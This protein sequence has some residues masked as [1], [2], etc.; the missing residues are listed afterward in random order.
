[1]ATARRAHLRY[2]GSDVALVV[3]YGSQSELVS[4]FEETHRQ[5]Y[6]FHAPNKLLIVESVTV[7]ATGAA[8]ASKQKPPSKTRS[9]PPAE[10][11]FPD[12]V[13]AGTAHKTPVYRR[14]DLQ[15]EDEIHGP[16]LIVEE[17]GT[18]VIEPGWKA[19]VTEL[20]YLL[21]TRAQPGTTDPPA[22][23]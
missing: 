1:I 4:T 8:V 15:P 14:S 7:E 3:P 5:R 12:L 6:G 11:A 21:L 16:A 10:L 9:G 2:E 19:Q 20:G 23:I 18:N 22:S 13:A 17:T